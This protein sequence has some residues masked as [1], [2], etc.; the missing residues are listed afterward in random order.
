MYIIQIRTLECRNFV[1]LTHNDTIYVEMTLEK[2]TRF[3]YVEVKYR[4]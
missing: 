1:V 2:H 3:L 4:L